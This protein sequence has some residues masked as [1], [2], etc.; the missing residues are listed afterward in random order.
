M[1]NKPTYTFIGKSFSPIENGIIKNEDENKRYKLEISLNRHKD[2]KGERCLVIL[3]NPSKAGLT[4][5]NE[6]DKTVN[7][8]CQYLFVRT[9]VINA[10]T[11]I[12]MNLFPVYETDSKKLHD[13]FIREY[14]VDNENKNYLKEEIEKADKIIVA[15]GTHPAKCLDP[16]DE[17]KRF[18]I[19]LLQ[20]KTCYQMKHPKFQ[21]NPN[22]PM[23]GQVWGY[24]KYELVAFDSSKIT[25][26]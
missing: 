17:M 3:K 26:K 8:V 6:S 11:V 9:D 7:T 1:K 5:I 10:N 20:N 18:V 4:D 25:H 14:L 2:F 22:K 15:W 21:I 12:I 19:P 23:H 24:E 13:D 16:F